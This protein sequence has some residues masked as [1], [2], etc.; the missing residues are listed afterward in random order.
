MKH[1]LQQLFSAVLAGCFLLVGNVPLALAQS[2]APQGIEINDTHFPDEK[3][4]TYIKENMDKNDDNTLSTEEADAVTYLYLNYEGIRDLTGIEH[5]PNLKTLHV[6]LNRLSTLDVSQNKKLSALYAGNNELTSL[7]LPNQQANDTLRHLD[8]FANQ[9]T[10][11]DLTNLRALDFLSAGDNLL[12]TLDLS[13]N[14]VGIRFIASYNFL[15]SVKLPN[16]GQ[17]YEWTEFLAEQSFPKGKGSGYQTVWYTDPQRTQALDPSQT[18]T[19]RL[20]GQTLYADYQ[21]IQYTVQFQPG[22]GSGTMEPQIFTYDQAQALRPNAFTKEHHT[23]AGWKMPNGKILTD[24]QQVNNLTFQKDKTIPL[25]ATWTERDYTG[26]AYTVNLH[27]NGGT[28]GDTTLHDAVYGTAYTL[29]AHSLEKEN[30]RFAGW[31]LASGGQ[32]VYEDGASVLIQHPEH[33]NGEALELYAV[34]EKQTYNV[35][36]VNGIESQTQTVAH[37]DAIVFPETPQKRGYTFDGWYTE[38]GRKW[39]AQDTVSQATTLYAKYEPISY[40]IAFH[41]NGAENETAMQQ[42][43][44]TLKFNQEGLLPQNA[45]TKPYH[46]FAGWSTEAGGEVAYIDRANVVEAADTEGA[47][48]DLYAV[49]QQNTVTVTLKNGEQTEQKTLNQGDVLTLPVLEKTGYTFR[50]WKQEGTDTLWQQDDPVM[51]DMTLTADFAPIQYTVILD[52]NGADNAEEVTSSLSME[53]D[54]TQA[55]PQNQFTKANHTFTGWATEPE[56]P[57]V[58]PDQ[59]EIRNLTTEPS[60]QICL[61]AVW[62]RNVVS[63]TIHDGVRPAYD[64]AVGQGELLPEGL[65]PQREGYTLEGWYSEPTYQP[66]HRVDVTQPVMTAGALYANWTLNRYTVTFANVDRAPIE[67]TVEDSIALEAPYRA[68][69][70][71]LGWQDETGASVP[72]VIQNTA[73]DMTLTA[74]WQKIEETLPVVTQPDDKEVIVGM[75]ETDRQQAQQTLADTIQNIALIDGND[76]Q[77]V[78]SIQ[79]AL[80]EGKQVTVQLSIDRLK[81]GRA[82]AAWL[83]QALETLNQG[84]YRFEAGS[85]VDISAIVRADSTV[86]GKLSELSAPVR[87]SI[88][89]PT[90]MQR[91]GRVYKVLALHDGQA[92]ELPASYESGIVT[93]ETQRFSTFALV[94]GDLVEEPLPETALP[95]DGAG[96]QP[97]GGQTGPQPG[98]AVQTGDGSQWALYAALL[99]LSAGAGAVCLRRKQ[100][101]A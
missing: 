6:E 75:Q 101:K 8:V 98:Q 80:Q 62:S 69:Y 78:A 33:L 12:T 86:L 89:V 53:Y 68:G 24:G 58:Y 32:A 5:F 9:L 64:M 41:G 35:T 99:A 3:F 43:G 88:A 65:A 27:A 70:D 84:S 46:T 97:M 17:T 2:S 50:G 51:Q 36:L 13:Q 48:L 83:R 94:Y 79:R 52:G 61:Y 38:E 49:W 66:E 96:S 22:G 4:R 40:S 63:V 15:E 90:Q 67:F 60:K 16:N 55:L 1:K 71:F 28:G 30:Y 14:P 34:W 23:F 82:Q 11:L 42:S 73:K 20:E 18:P 29:P 45:F 21:P 10:A 56:G 25:T 91:T 44:L 54:K 93:F 47:V 95:Q 31:A 74:V 100:G 26:E 77:L 81:Q 37:G 59:A 87:F 7:I 85:V 72:S 39:E 76:A 57:V 92:Y 19:L